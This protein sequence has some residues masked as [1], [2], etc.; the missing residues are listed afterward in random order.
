MLFCRRCGLGH[1]GNGVM[2][3]QCQQRH[4]SPMCPLDQRRRRERTVGSRAVAVQ[5]DFHRRDG[6]LTFIQWIGGLQ[7]ASTA[8]RLSASP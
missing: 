5:I 2:V 3:G 8:S 4:A 6:S 7:P 1:P